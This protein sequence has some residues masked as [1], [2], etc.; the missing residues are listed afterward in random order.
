MKIV[1]ILGGL[2]NQMFQ[3]ALAL[4]LKNRYPQE[5]V[6][7]DIRGFKG[8]P[9]HNGYELDKIFKLSIGKA[10]MSHQASLFYPLYNYR[11]WQI[12]N[13]FLPKR[14]TVV[15]ESKDNKYSPEILDR[16]SSTYYLG[17]WQT[18]K[19]FSDIR[20]QIIKAFQFPEINREDKNYTILKE[21]ENKNSISLHVRKGDYLKVE[22]TQGICTLN[23]YR[24]A[25][26]YAIKNL[27][28]DIF[29]V[30]SDD[31]EW[32]RNNLDEYFGEIPSVYIDWNKDAN[33]FRD[34]QLMSLCHHNIIA[35]S[36]FS[37]WGAWL[38]QHKDKI[39]ISPS[40]WMKGTGW[41]D[42]IPESWIKIKS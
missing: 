34:M 6:L 41:E 5:K 24:G 1:N 9:L 35:N 28:P 36:S 40:C 38:N 12:A 31:I 21:I 25:I 22:N 16:K 30:F 20:P 17:Y 29:I 33:S 19:Y 11:M 13:R 42:T 10:N 27:R 37:W 23:Y 4:A 2:G 3:Y 32:C 18:E 14:R 39:V 7:I 15:R 26:D 8:Y